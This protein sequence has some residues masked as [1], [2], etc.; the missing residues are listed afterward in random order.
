MRRDE[1]STSGR[2]GSTLVHTGLL[3]RRA[4][5]AVEEEQL[6]NDIDETLVGRTL[7]QVERDHVVVHV[8]RIDAA[9]AASAVDRAVHSVWTTP[10]ADVSD[11]SWRLIEKL[12]AAG[13]TQIVINHAYLGAKIEQAIGT[14]ARFGIQ[15]SYSA[16]GEALETAGGIAHALPLLGSEAFAAVNAD[17]FSDYDYAF[18]ARAV[19]E[20]PHAHC[21]A[22]LVLVDNPDHNA[23][24]DFALNSDTVVDDGARLTFSGIAAY[25]PV[26]FEEIARGSKANPRSASSTTR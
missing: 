23:T 10:P 19:G 20:L 2:C 5:L 15:I 13:F 25:Q 3:S 26:M 8:H 1:C 17:V 14:G 11:G 6:A 4:R 18:L 16:E 9:S 7:G 22:H 21:L 12:A 24:G